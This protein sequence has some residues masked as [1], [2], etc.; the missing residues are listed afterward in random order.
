MSRSSEE[1]IGYLE[2]A[3]ADVRGLALGELIKRGNSAI[4][5]LIEALGNTNAQVRALAAE[6]LATIAKPSTADNLAAALNDAD[7]RVRAQAATGL[8][9]MNDS[10]AIQALIRT[11]GDNP[12][13]LHIP[14]T[15]SAT[16]LI[17]MGPRVLP[18]LARALKSEDESTRIRAIWIIQ[19]IV[20]RLPEPEGDWESLSRA[21]GHFD[22]AGPAEERNRIADRWLSWAQDHTEGQ[23]REG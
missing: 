6:G 21:L 19:E 18:E 23:Q 10:R 4:T 11:L 12:D 22:P 7:G 20:S 2:N 14:Y 15:Q 3:D 9:R 1:L 8:A 13:L 16:T 17:E 5:S